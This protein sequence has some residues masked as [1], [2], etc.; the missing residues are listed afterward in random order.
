MAV[1]IGLAFNVVLAVVKVLIGILG[2]SSALLADGVNSTS[3]VAYYIAVRVFVGM[4][5]KPP[6]GEHPYGH[7]QLESI[8]ALV[9]GSFVITTAVAIFWDAVN[10]AYDMLVT[11]TGG[12]SISIMALW[13]ALGTVAIK[14]GLASVTRKIGRRTHNAAILALAQDHRNDIIAASGA[15]LG[16]A[17]GRAGLAWADPLAGALV[18]VLV[19]ITGLG[20]LRDSSA[21]LM[22]TVPGQELDQEIRALVMRVRG[23]RDAEE[24]QAHRF[25]PYLVVNVTIGIDGALSVAEGD[26]I[27][28][29]VEQILL[30]EVSLLRR[31]Y[32]H[33][34]PARGGLPAA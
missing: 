13:V 18:S 22:D 15:A 3:D 24:I 5:H 23:V 1:N 21:D 30:D 16:V 2:H 29:D 32:V 20:I 28:N 33:Y 10:S 19:L 11:D 8:G 34:H 17:L 27:A 4:A 26:R 25:G 6:D 12:Q 7:S 14:I 31:A 9:V